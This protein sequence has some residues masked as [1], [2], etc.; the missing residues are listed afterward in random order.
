MDDSCG[1]FFLGTALYVPSGAII[2]TFVA[3][4]ALLIAYATVAA[5][6]LS[7]RYVRERRASKF[8]AP[9]EG[10]AAELLAPSNLPSWPIAMVAITIKLSIPALLALDLMHQ[11]NTTPIRLIERN[12]KLTYPTREENLEFLL[13]ALSKPRSHNE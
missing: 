5:F 12:G 11:I 9:Q 8:R 3:C 2:W 1:W 4:M 6:A 10:E 13:E 7:A